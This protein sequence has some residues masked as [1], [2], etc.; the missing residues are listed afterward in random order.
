MRIALDAMGGDFAPRALVAG[1]MEA[2]QKFPD[3]EVFL[4]GDR[5]S[6]AA[7]MEDFGGTTKKD[8]NSIKIVHA[9]QSISMD[10]IPLVALKTKP[11]SSLLK[12]VEMVAEGRADAVVS[13]GNT[14]AMV[15]ACT[16]KLRTLKG[17]KRAGIAAN[18]PTKNGYCTLI[19][20]GANVHCKP[21]HL[22]Q[23][24]I[25]A[26]I[27]N[28]AVLNKKR[29]VVGLLN[30]G[31]EQ[32]KGNVLVRKTMALLAD[33]NLDYTGSVEGN[34]IFDGKCDVVVCEGFAGN[35]ILKA[36]EGLS[37]SLLGSLQTNL[38]RDLWSR[39]GF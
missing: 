28:I 16:F 33:S 27:Y 23:Y 29:P 7:S 31:E 9:T 12:A 26:A 5:E 32:T 8:Q 36:A 13:A 30:V 15:A 6:I 21:I 20:V 34:H 11:D 4:V 38:Q 3:V 1:A 19:D 18:L 14:G 2:A 17:V 22:Y 39:L 25:M 37:E 35:V 24:G 10:E